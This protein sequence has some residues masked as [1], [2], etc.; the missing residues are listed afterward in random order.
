MT[1][2][3][4]VSKRQAS[5]GF[6]FVTLFLDVMGLG[7]IIPVLPKL[8]ESFTGGEAEASRIFGLMVALYAAMQFLFAPILGSL[9]DKYGR[10]AVILISLTGAGIDYLLLAFAPNLSW[11]FVGRVIAG[12]TAAN[13]TAVTAYIADISTPEKRAQN[14]GMVGMAFGLGFIAGPVLGGLLGNIGLRIPF[15]VVA[16]ITL[17]NAVYGFFVLPESLKP[18]NRREFSWARANPIGSLAGLGRYPI[19]LGLAGVT[20]LS[21]LAQNALQSIWVLYTSHRFS[22]DTGDVGIS[23]AVVG[24]SAALVQGGLTGRI[25]PKIGERR[26]IIYGLG[27]GCI[28]N[29]LYG[30]ANQGWMMY[31]I[32]FLGALGFIAGPSTQALISK[33]VKSNEQGST[34]GAITSILSLT[35]VIGPLIATSVFSYFIGE[36][37]PFEL[38]G[39]SFFLGALFTLFAMFLAQW[40]FARVPVPSGHSTVEP[41]ADGTQPLVH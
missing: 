6:I 14:F 30:L 2:A 13:I 29:V 19:V 17:L 24:L 31:L 16:G 25:V 9:S 5:L 28:A 7:L 8:V 40:L 4:S 10:R 18:E 38:P 32:P 34:Q 12:I 26:A 22:W 3:S 39:A 1:T 37:A 33:S 21:G 23:L 11:L 20:V 15:L 27:I 36:N 41:L 35:G